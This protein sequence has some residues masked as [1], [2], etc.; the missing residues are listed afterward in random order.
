MSG[1]VD[2]RT[3][4]LPELPPLDESA[5]RQVAQRWDTLTKPAGSLGRLE[6]LACRI[7]SIQGRFRPSSDRKSVV[8]FAA[9]H[10]VTELGVSSYPKAVT[11]AMVE[12]FARGGAAICVL[13]R[14][15]DARLTVVD[16]GVDGPVGASGPGVLSRRVRPGTRNMVREAAMTPEETARA[17]ETGREV[18]RDLTREGLDLLAVGDMGIGNT[19]AASA[20]LAGI[21]GCPPEQVVGPGTGLDEEGLRRKRRVVEEALRRT[22]EDRQDLRALLASVGGLEIAAMAGAYLEAASR[23]VPVVLDGV[24]STAAAVWASRLKPDLAGFCIASHMSPE[25]GHRLGLQLLG[26]TPLL[27][28]GLRLGEATG[29]AL[30][31][32]LCEAACRLLNDMSTFEEAGV[33]SRDRTSRLPGTESRGYP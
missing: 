23:R 29:A 3:F 7:A 14:W 32:A 26:L 10:G 15:V 27:D 17:F 30:G 22:G 9:D 20:L 1:P 11:R 8:I 5:R 13:A 25:P 28:L 21:T 6:D 31:L 2:S 4:P 24:I 18:V 12:N 19:T 33:P 16:V